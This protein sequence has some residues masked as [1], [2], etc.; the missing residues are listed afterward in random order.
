VTF[1]HIE[2]LG[3]PVAIEYEWVG[4]AEAPL[5]VFLH[6]GLGSL[7]MWRDFPARLAGALGKRGLVYSRPGYGKSTPRA[8]D[9]RWDVDFM[10]RQAQEVLPAVLEAVG[11]GGERPWF[12]GHSDGGSIA[13]IYS[14]TSPD[15]VGGLIVAAPHVFVEDL[16]ITSIERARAAYLE[17]DL[18]DKLARHHEDVDSAFWGWNDI[19]LHPPFRQWNIERELE[20]IR[21]PVLALQGV[22]DEYG[23]L[24]QIRR[25]AR[26]VPAAQ[27]LE[28]ERC[29]HSPHRDQ[30]DA[31]IAAAVR[32][33]GSR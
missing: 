29:G 10:H 22:D 3:R 31:V 25:I 8:D 5:I 11:A 33:A 28:I 18:R 14:A 6:E 23:T 2:W 17:T 19:W 1:A 4:A 9:E 12:Y 21:C 24:E 30:P 13:L 26:R 16:S 27:L 7:S 15:R 32:F 20:A